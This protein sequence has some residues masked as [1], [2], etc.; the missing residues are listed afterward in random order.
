MI[1]LLLTVAPLLATL[2]A[3]SKCLLQPILE[4]VLLPGKL[5]RALRKIVHLRARLLLAHAVQH[6]L[7]LGQALGGAARIGLRLRLLT[8]LLALLGRPHVV[9]RLIQAVERLLHLLLLLLADWPPLADC[10]DWPDC[11]D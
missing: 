10:P 2:V 6:A 4:I 1:P 5:I 3:L 7:R 9:Q 8:L 11:P